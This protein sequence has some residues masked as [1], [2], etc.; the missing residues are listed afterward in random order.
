MPPP[1]VLKP[2]WNVSCNDY[3][4]NRSLENLLMYQLLAFWHLKTS[5]EKSDW[6]IPC[7]FWILLFLYLT[8]TGEKHRTQEPALPSDS[9]LIYP[10]SIRSGRKTLSMRWS[11][12]VVIQEQEK[13]EHYHLTATG[14]HPI[15]WH[16]ANANNLVGLLSAF[17]T[18]RQLSTLVLDP[19]ALD[20][21]K[22]VSLTVSTWSPWSQKAIP[23]LITLSWVTQWHT[24]TTSELGKQQ[25]Q[26]WDNS[27][28]RGH[29]LA[30]TNPAWW[31]QER[32][33]SMGLRFLTC[34]ATN[35]PVFS[36]PTIHRNLQ[37][38]KN[39][40]WC[41]EVL[42]MVSQSVCSSLA[43]TLRVHIPQEG[44][45][46][47]HHRKSQV[48]HAPRCFAEGILKS[49]RGSLVLVCLA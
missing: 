20:R 45:S 21:K 13:R 25:H 4:L 31:R 6:K 34:N 1:Q 29:V 7:I 10:A 15:Q 12:V 30:D 14:L 24:P 26:H 41:P 33:L 48:G 18:K 23:N 32:G 42:E 5:R 40:V 47:S 49:V 16:L 3:I 46:H 38:E 27:L 36:C 17:E 22:K 28:V 39:K 8:H 19:S 37:E 2:A 11:F 9:M 44:V 43:L 35:L